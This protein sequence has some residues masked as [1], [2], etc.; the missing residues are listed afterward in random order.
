M[1]DLQNEIDRYGRIGKSAPTTNGQAADVSSTDNYESSGDETPPPPPEFT[2]EV[3]PP[4]L[5]PPC[6]LP[7]TTPPTSNSTYM[8]LTKPSLPEP[9]GPPPPP[10]VQNGYAFNTPHIPQ[11]VRNP[12]GNLAGKNAGDSSGNGAINIAANAKKPKEPIYESIKPRPEPLGGPAEEEPPMEYGFAMT[13]QQQQQLQQRTTA[14]R[15]PPLPQ[16][17]AQNQNGVYGKSPLEMEREARRMVRVRRELERI[18]V[19]AASSKD[20]KWG[21]IWPRWPNQVPVKKLE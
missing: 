3:S 9:E 15:R 4:P 10:P 13:Q 18:Q 20:P 11:E 14:N 19:T 16:V 1:S 6:I 5:P 12:L 17:P 7:G 8:M 21:L 2:R